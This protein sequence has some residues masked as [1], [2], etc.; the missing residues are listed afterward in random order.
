MTDSDRAVLERNLTTDL[1][2]TSG[3][4]AKASIEALRFL[5]EVGDDLASTTVGVVVHSHSS[6]DGDFVKVSFQE[7]TTAEIVE[8]LRDP[9]T[10]MIEVDVSG[11]LE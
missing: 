7:L 10:T 9:R 11:E 6:S 8:V 1:S 3:Q 5:V 4:V 2:L